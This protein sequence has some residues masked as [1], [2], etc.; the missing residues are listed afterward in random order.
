MDS[1]FTNHKVF[2]QPRIFDVLSALRLLKL[3]I[4][5]EVGCI[6]WSKKAV[7]RRLSFGWSQNGT[8]HANLLRRQSRDA[9]RK[10]KSSIGSIFWVVFA[11]LAILINIYIQ[12]LWWAQRCHLDDSDQCVRVVMNRNRVK[13]WNEATHL[14]MRK[15]ALK[16]KRCLSK[17]LHVHLKSSSRLQW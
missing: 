15:H 6:L 17:Y 1:L 7:V 10:T 8:L 16:Q 13:Q 2:L 3:K 9:R 5:T 4:T 12:V 14:I 11:I